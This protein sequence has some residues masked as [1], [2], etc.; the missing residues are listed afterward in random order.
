MRNKIAGFIIMGISLIIGIIIYAFNRALSQIVKTSCSHGDSCPMWG[1]ISFHT[2]ISTVI[3][4][5]IFLIGVYLVFFGREEKI[6]TKIRTVKLK[7]KKGIAV[8]KQEDYDEK[9]KKA[10]STLTKEEK[11]VV[12]SVMEKQGAIFQSEIA[13]KTGY[14]KVK[15]TRILDRLEGQGII[16]R[17]RRGMTNMVIFK[18]KKD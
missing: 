16:E 15:V 8:K 18:N 12:E 7:E 5:L 10:M 3:M 17:R 14:T 11:A 1:S 6:I 9:I 4:V 13:E 2:T